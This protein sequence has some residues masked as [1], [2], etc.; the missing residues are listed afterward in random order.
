MRRSRCRSPTAARERSTSCSAPSAA[1]ASARRRAILS[2]GRSRPRFGLLANGTAI[3]ESAAASG[4]Q[5]VGEA[6]R[7]AVAASSRGTGELIVAAVEAGA[8]EVWVAAGGSATTDGGAGALEVLDGAGIDPSLTVLCD[9]RTPFELAART[10]GPQKGASAGQ[11]RTLERRLGRLAERAP[12]DPRGVPLSGAAG[13]LSGGLWAYRRAKLAH[14]ASFILDAVGFDAL[15][16]AARFVVTG[17]G[18]LDRQTLQ[19]KGVFEVATRCRQG[20]VACH[21][22]VGSEALDRFDERLIDLSTVREAGS[23]DELVEAGRELA[24]L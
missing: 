12:R 21:A 1:S 2:G 11:L 24:T 15:M 7:D 4:L 13:G 19:G 20:G 9:V 16:R 18:R 3:V 22:V 6:E 17:E 10:F 8:T 23:A 14:G 5:L